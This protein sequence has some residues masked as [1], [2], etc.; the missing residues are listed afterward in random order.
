MELTG[1]IIKALPI[2]SGTSQKG[3]EWR[4]ATYVIEFT[5]GQ[6]PRHLAFDVLNSKIEELNVREGESLTVYFDINAREYNGKWYNSIEAWKVSRPQ[7]QYQPQPQPQ[8]QQVI[9]PDKQEEEHLP[10]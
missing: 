9:Y 8:P 7:P 5:N 6:Y 10:F 1:T 2:Q 4:R 3:N